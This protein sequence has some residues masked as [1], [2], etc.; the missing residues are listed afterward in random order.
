MPEAPFFCDR[1]ETQR[2]RA[3]ADDNGPT[4]RGSHGESGLGLEE[5]NAP[6]LALP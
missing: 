6:A 2:Q 5:S 1:Q 4:S 3:C